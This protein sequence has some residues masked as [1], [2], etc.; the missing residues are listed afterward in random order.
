M[1][2]NGILHIDKISLQLVRNAINE[3]IIIIFAKVFKKDFNDLLTERNNK[4][5]NNVET[6]NETENTTVNK[7]DNYNKMYTLYHSSSKYK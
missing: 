6:E 2:K 4:Q 1:A 7:I 3:G 5:L